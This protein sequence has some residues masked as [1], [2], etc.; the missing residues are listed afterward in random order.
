MEVKLDFIWRRRS[1]RKYTPQPVSEE[2]I[3]AILQAA[4]AAPSAHNR[5][6]WHFIVIRERQTLNYIAEQHPYAKMLSE[7]PLAI[8]VCGDTALSPK[9]WDQDCAAATENILLALPA[10]GLGGVWIGYH[11]IDPQQDFLRPLFN[12]PPHVQVFC[13]ISIGQPAEVK[14]PRTQFDPAVVHREKW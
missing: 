8:A 6:P 12:L 9:R 4:M 3:L 2:Q 10:L 13:L 7:A 11:P 1:I 5:K 14:E